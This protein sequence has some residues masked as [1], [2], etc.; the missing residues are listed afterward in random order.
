MRC[1]TAAGMNQGQLAR[2]DVLSCP[3][4]SSG[5]KHS[6]TENTVTDR[7]AWD[8]GQRGEIR[9][10]PARCMGSCFCRRRARV[11]KTRQAAEVSRL[12][13]IHSPH[14]TGPR[15]RL[16]HYSGPCRKYG[17]APGCRLARHLYCTRH[18][19]HS[20]QLASHLTDIPAP[21]ASVNSLASI[22]CVGP[23]PFLLSDIH[24]CIT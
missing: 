12:P 6:R 20:R 4:A 14:V 11:E 3:P 21:S 8:Q 13:P 2:L 16:D 7:R 22:C 23:A 5:A 9:R 18:T 1:S 10:S 24:Y 15:P 17:E 19:L